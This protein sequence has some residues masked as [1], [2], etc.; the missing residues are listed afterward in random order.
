M[1]TGAIG[2]L[3][4]MPIEFQ[5]VRQPFSVSDLAVFR[6]RKLGE[7]AISRF[8]VAWGLEPGAWELAGF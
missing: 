5:I 8:A 4:P 7:R 3:R 1:A 2:G 6:L